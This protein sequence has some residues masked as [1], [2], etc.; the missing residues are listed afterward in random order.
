MGLLL[1]HEYILKSGG[2]RPNIFEHL[3][4]VICV[5][6]TESDIVH[7]IA[8]IEL[9]TSY[10]YVLSSTKSSTKVTSF[11]ALNRNRFE[12]ACKFLNVR[13]FRRISDVARWILHIVRQCIRV[14]CYPELKEKEIRPTR[15]I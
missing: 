11:N 14:Q 9:P 6:Y 12:L 3:R 4:S 7:T 8:N 10:T 2:G 1:E 15:R 13:N 5:W